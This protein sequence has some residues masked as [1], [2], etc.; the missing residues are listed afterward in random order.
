MTLKAK[1]PK[2]DVRC[3]IYVRVCPEEHAKIV[4]IA[5]ERGRPHTIASVATE[6]ISRGLQNKDAAK[7]KVIKPPTSR[8]SRE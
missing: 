2:R 8:R 1:K 6:M 5:E 3:P 4:Q 7:P